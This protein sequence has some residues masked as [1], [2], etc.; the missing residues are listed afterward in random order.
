M[1]HYQCR[2][3]VYNR[4]DYVLILY[5]HPACAYEVVLNQQVAKWFHQGWMLKW[6]NYYDEGI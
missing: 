6:M 4:F 1:K 3:W 2:V 5:R